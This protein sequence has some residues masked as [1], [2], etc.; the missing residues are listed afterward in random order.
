MKKKRI[1]GFVSVFAIIATIFSNFVLL[2]KYIYEDVYKEYPEFTNN[3]IWIFSLFAF[4]GVIIAVLKIKKSKSY[5]FAKTGSIG[6]MLLAANQFLIG[7]FNLYNIQVFLNL[8]KINS[9]TFIVTLVYMCFV[10]FT[11]IYVCFA[12]LSAVEAAGNDLGKRIVVSFFVLSVLAIFCPN[13]LAYPLFFMIISAFLFVAAFFVAGNCSENVEIKECNDKK[14]VPFSILEF[15]FMMVGAAYIKTVPYYNGSEKVLSSYGVSFAIPALL[16]VTIF[17]IIKLIKKDNVLFAVSGIMFAVATI[18]SGVYCDNITVFTI[19]YVVAMS[20]WFINIAFAFDY[21][22]S[23]TGYVKGI[24]VCACTI[25]LPA[26]IGYIIAVIATKGFGYMNDV[27]SAIYLEPLRTNAEI[28]KG[29]TPNADGEFAAYKG[30]GEVIK[31][32]Y[33]RNIHYAS[34]IVA[35]VCGGV[36]SLVSIVDSFLNKTKSK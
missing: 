33:R 15:V 13:V 12:L 2:E 20:G 3:T 31:L 36:S 22:F 19:C 10:A 8:T 6:F 11:G 34:P 26:V 30:I 29:L 23:N 18:L 9:I 5:S 25:L 17:L 32:T 1:T 21:I 4:V 24:I 28:S 27:F 14:I 7:F 16:A 35:Y